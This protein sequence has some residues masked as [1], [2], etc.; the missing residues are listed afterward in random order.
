M[1]IKH[2]H[3]QTPDSGEKKKEMG[4]PRANS[5]NY[6]GYWKNYIY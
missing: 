5:V 3:K 1:V 6:W 2:M 4:V